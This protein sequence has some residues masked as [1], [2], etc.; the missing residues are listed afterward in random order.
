MTRRVRDAVKE[1]G[2]LHER[3]YILLRR[4]RTGS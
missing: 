3:R 2:S 4:K 1:I